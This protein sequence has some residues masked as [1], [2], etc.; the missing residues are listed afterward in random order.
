[1]GLFK[2]LSKL[3]AKAKAASKFRHLGRLLKGGGAREVA[4]PAVMNSPQLSLSS[5]VDTELDGGVPLLFFA[6]DSTF[7]TQGGNISSDDSSDGGVYISSPPA[8]I[9]NL[10]VISNGGN[11]V[12]SSSK[13]E[14]LSGQELDKALMSSPGGPWDAYA[15]CQHEGVPSSVL[16]SITTAGA[17]ERCYR[18]EG[19]LRPLFCEVKQVYLARM[20]T[21]RAFSTPGTDLRRVVN[22][23]GPEA[24]LQRDLQR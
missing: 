17:Q 19:R 18:L 23:F 4:C 15:A 8:S 14:P 10:P 12:R 5:Y 11:S 1:M 6:A 24:H 21:G 3:P 16:A 9:V 7:N 2:L 20:A 22:M 13:G